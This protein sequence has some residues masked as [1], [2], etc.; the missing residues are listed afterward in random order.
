M[1]WA[2]Y[3][4]H[5]IEPQ[6]SSFI[7]AYISSNFVYRT[8]SI[9]CI[10]PCPSSSLFVVCAF[11]LCAF[12]IVVHRHGIGEISRRSD[13]LFSPL[14]MVKLLTQHLFWVMMCDGFY[15]LIS[16]EIDQNYFQRLDICIHK[17]IKS[18][19]TSFSFTVITSLAY[20]FSFFLWLN[21]K[22]IGTFVFFLLFCETPPL[23]QQHLYF[24]RVKI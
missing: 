18:L 8:P 5:K 6:K 17:W 20:L 15:M 21:V 4:N 22:T 23:S 1:L 16:I 14:P 7:Y 24:C 19:H 11:V 9:H 13:Y 12:Y 2:F 10:Y 3:A